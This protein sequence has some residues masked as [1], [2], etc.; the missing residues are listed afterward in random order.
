MLDCPITD[1]LDDDR[2]PLWLE[3]HLHPGGLQ[4]PHGGSADRRLFRAQGDFPASR[5]RACD[6]YDTGLRGPIFAKTQQPPAPLVLLLRGMAKGEPTA[7]RARELT[8][9]RTQLQTLRQRLPANR[10]ETAP[11][12]G[13]PGTACEA[14]ALYHNAGA[15]PPA[16]S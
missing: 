14:D 6:G 7:R 12:D 11:T 1:V 15:Q 9:S 16:P 5:W 2:C 3:R 8:L 10:N 13:M 4:W